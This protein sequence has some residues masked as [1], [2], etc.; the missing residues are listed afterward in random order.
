M[1][2]Q[3][4]VHAQIRWAWKKFDNLRARTQIIW[5]LRSFRNRKKLQ[6]KKKE[7]SVLW[8]L[9]ESATNQTC[10]NAENL[11]VMH[12]SFGVDFN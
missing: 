5:K 3:D 8:E 4:Y 1:Y 9:I 10:D 6:Y 12:F 11:I 7:D 2:E